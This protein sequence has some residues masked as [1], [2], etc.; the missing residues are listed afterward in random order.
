MAAAQDMNIYHLDVKT[1]FLNGELEEEIYMK[2][3]ECYEADATRVCRLIKSLYGLRQAP[4]AWFNKLKSEL[5]AMGFKTSDADPS[6]YTKNENGVRTYLLVYVD[7]ILIFS[8]KGGV[9]DAHT[10]ERPW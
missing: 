6:L 1:A 5:E 7:D 8:S 2:Q 10:A 3:P 4:R 9:M